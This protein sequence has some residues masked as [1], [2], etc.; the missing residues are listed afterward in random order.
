MT[1]ESIIEALLPVSRNQLYLYQ[2]G[3]MAVFAVIG[4]MLA[5]VRTEP[6]RSF[7]IYPVLRS[8]GSGAALRSPIRRG[9]MGMLVSRATSSAVIARES[10]RSSTHRLREN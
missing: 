2:I 4:W 8:I 1:I 7:D 5:L 6:N 3:C 9:L 10:G